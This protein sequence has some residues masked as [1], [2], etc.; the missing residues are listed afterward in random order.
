MSFRLARAASAVL[1]LLALV[2]VLAM[3]SAVADDGHVSYTLPVDGPVVDGWRP[4]TTPYGPGNRG[5]DLGTQPG[6]MVRAAADG[7]VTFAGRIGSWWHVVVLHAD[8]IRTSYSFLASVEVRRGERV[9]Q[10][11]VVG[12][13]GTT[14][15]FG[16]R[17][18]NEYIDPTVL[19]GG[20]PPKVHLVPVDG[21]RPLTEV[22][23]RRSLLDGLRGLARLPTGAALGAGAQTLVGLVADAGWRVVEPALLHTEAE[24]RR[25]EEGARAAAHALNVP[26]WYTASQVRAE[27]IVR[28][29]AACT[30]A[31]APLPPAPARRIVVLVGGLSSSSASTDGIGAVDT[32]ALGYAPGDVVRFSYTGGQATPGLDGIPVNPYTSADTYGD[33]GAAGDR[34]HQLLVDVSRTHPGVAVDIIAHSPGGLVARAALN[35]IDAWRPDM[36]VIA[37]V[38][39]LATPHHGSPWATANAVLG[40]TGDGPAIQAAVA[41]LGVPA[42]SIAVQQL[43]SASRFIAGLNKRSMPAGTHFT[44]I[45]GSGDLVVG[46]SRSAVAGATNVLVDIR[47][48]DA[49]Q[50]LPGDPV[51]LREMQ[52][53]TR[54]AGP[55][56]RG[57]SSDLRLAWAIETVGQNPVLV[58]RVR[59]AIDHLGPKVPS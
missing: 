39:T 56:C 55:T 2:P 41:E 32:A 14:V 30:P 35:G 45:A 18:G 28:A 46:A 25:Y 11:D 16:A 6:E 49:H 59:D 17:A 47:G 3:P 9:A 43:S 1:L 54:G 5:I 10:G 15:H 34:L 31:D 42:D 44:S 4:P 7:T 26:G 23:E 13:A 22:Q 8:G 20:G 37:D 57:L 12:V 52:L 48:I 36:P 38:V 21:Q 40:V 27:R 58:A 24:L 19:L 29:Q 50:K 33:L 51:A 53:A